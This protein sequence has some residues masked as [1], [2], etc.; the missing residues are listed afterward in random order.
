MNQTTLIRATKQAAIGLVLVGGLVG[1][2]GFGFHGHCHGEKFFRHMIDAHVEEALDK[3]D[4]NPTQRQQ[5]SAIE[6]KLIADGK[7]MRDAH[8]SILAQLAAQFPNAQLDMQALDQAAEP[9]KQAQEKLRQDIRQAVSDIHAILT[10][11]Q[12]QKLSDL[13]KSESTRCDDK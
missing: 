8:Q 3:I 12:R 4:A 13:M 10:P 2:A 9:Q 1:L 5:V 6:D 11:T 7:A